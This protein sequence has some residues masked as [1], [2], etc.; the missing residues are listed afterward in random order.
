MRSSPL[1]SARFVKNFLLSATAL[2]LLSGCAILDKKD[3]DEESNWFVRQFEKD[4]A[5]DA[6]AAT[7]AYSQG[8]FKKALEYALDSLK[9]NPRNQQALLVGA[10]SSEKLGR[11]NRARQYYEDLIIIDGKETFFFRGKG[12]RTRGN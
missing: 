1:F 6:T 3:T 7:V 2:S 9:A 8:D 4:G 10:L 5:Q 12:L 11:F